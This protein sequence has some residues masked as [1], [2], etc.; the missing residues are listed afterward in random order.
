MPFRFYCGARPGLSDLTEDCPGWAVRPMRWL[1]SAAPGRLPRWI[2]PSR[3]RSSALFG[4]KKL[5]QSRASG[6]CEM[7]LF[8]CLDTIAITLI[9]KNGLEQVTIYVYGIFT[10][11]KQFI[12]LKW[13]K[14]CSFATLARRMIS[15]KNKKRASKVC[16]FRRRATKL[17]EVPSLTTP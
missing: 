17:S 10:C 14:K 11:L 1:A 6:V 3:E 5:A 8:P 9:E 4:P 15:C 13:T 7:R 12:P 2:R 16:A